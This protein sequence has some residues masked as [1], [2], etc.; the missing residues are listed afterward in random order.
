MIYDIELY[1][2]PTPPSWSK[3]EDE[4]VAWEQGV[5]NKPNYDKLIADKKMKCHTKMNSILALPLSQLAVDNLIQLSRQ[6]L[7]IIRCCGAC[8][9]LIDAYQKCY[10]DIHIKTST[11]QQRTDA[12]NRLKALPIEETYKRVCNEVIDSSARLLF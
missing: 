1:T 10:R 5:A 3:V 7:D 6:R 2:N 8:N 12:F 9:E 11:N 4:V